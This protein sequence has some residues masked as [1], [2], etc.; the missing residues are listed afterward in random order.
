M[1]IALVEYIGRNGKVTVKS[2]SSEEEL[3]A[4]VKKLEAKGTKHLVTRL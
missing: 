4:F 3:A 1:I 2:M